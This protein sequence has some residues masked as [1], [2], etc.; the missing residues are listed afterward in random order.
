M[1][2][3]YKIGVRIG[4]VDTTGGGILKNCGQFAKAQKEASAFLTTLRKVNEEFRKT[5]GG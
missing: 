1:F 3:A 2:E 4:I 5:S